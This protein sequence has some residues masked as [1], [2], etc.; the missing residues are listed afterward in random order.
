MKILILQYDNRPSI[1][2]LDKLTDINKKYAV[3]HN[4]EYLF[5][6]RKMDIPMYW[7]KVFL[8]KEL[9]GQYKAIMWM[10]TDAVIH[11]FEAKI[12]WFGRYN[13]SMILTPDMPPYQSPF[14]AGVFIIRNDHYGVKILNEWTE[15]YK[16]VQKYWTNIGTHWHCN[17]VWAGPAYEQGSFVS[18]M[19]KYREN[20]ESISY[21]ILQAPSDEHI[22]KT[23][24]SM[25][26]AGVNKKHIGT[27]LQQHH[28][29]K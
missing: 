16:D 29:K 18:I 28:N 6:T 21:H 24:F 11:N 20:I 26:F 14:C 7:I 5:I 25:H 27:Y 10:D 12:E 19:Q 15:I 22:Q 3:R 17:D 9:I 13:K 2:P 23:T 8:L 1:R 4:Y